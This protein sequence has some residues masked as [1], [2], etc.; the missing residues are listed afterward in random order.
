MPNKVQSI[1]LDK[2]VPHPDNPNRMSRSTFG[3]LVR[4]IERT[5][6]YEPLVVRPCPKE[7]GYFQ[8]ISGHHRCKALRELGY[9]TADAVVWDVDDE[10]VDILLATLNRL[11]GSDVL[12][13]KLALLKKLN[14]RMRSRELAKL[15][16]QTPRQIERLAKFR[17][18]T[19]P[20]RIDA[21]TFAMPLV[22]FLNSR[23]KR[24]IDKALSR[25]Q[26]KRSER[27]K[28][29]IKAAALTDVAQHYLGTH[30]HEG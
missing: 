24:T 8:I 2:L 4:N 15:L 16:P 23:Q 7:K 12:D 25:A 26:R 13:K 21:K 10:Q 11:T 9:K 6:R 5:G 14:A 28:A 29:A 19:A 20:A 17:L 22:F 18:P 1:A 27:T 30:E 3:K